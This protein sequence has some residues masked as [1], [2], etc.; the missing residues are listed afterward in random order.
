VTILMMKTRQHKT[1]LLYLLFCSI[2]IQLSAGC[3]VKGPSARPLSVSEWLQTTEMEVVL[4]WPP[5]LNS[6]FF[7]GPAFVSGPS[8]YVRILYGSRT[9][10]S[11]E[12]FTFYVGQDSNVPVDFGRNRADALSHFETVRI[13]GQSVEVEMLTRARLSEQGVAVFQIN[14]THVVIQW[15]GV[16]EQAMLTLLEENIVHLSPNDLALIT[17]INNAIS[18]IPE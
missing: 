10:L 4:F 17:D 13:A 18:A 5:P 3:Y 11:T 14:D 2:L 8:E 9:T 16:D 15:K 6:D 7:L 1:M 12:S